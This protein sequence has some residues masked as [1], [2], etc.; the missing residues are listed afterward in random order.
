VNN[1]A[2]LKIDNMHCGCFGQYAS[3]V[4][5]ILNVVK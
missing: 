2:P 1:V 3:Y 4:S 5:G